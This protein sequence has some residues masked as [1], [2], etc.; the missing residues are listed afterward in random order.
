MFRKEKDMGQIIAICNQKGGVGKTTA[1][2][3][4]GRYLAQHNYKT[5]LLDADPQGNLTSWLTSS[6]KNNGWIDTIVQ[7][8]HIGESLIIINQGWPTLA[9]LPGNNN[10]VHAL[11]WLKVTEAP[12]CTLRNLIHPLAKMADYVLIDMP[13]SRSSSF[14]QLLYACDQVLVPTELERHSIEGINLMAQTAN[15][16]KHEHSRGPKLLGIIPNKVRN[17]N[18]HKHYLLSIAAAHP[19][20]IWP[21]VPQSITVT[22]ATAR[23]LSVFD[24]APGEKVTRAWATVCARFVENTGG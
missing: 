19:K 11:A 7:G 10:T 13:P 6:L 3:T 21:P 20:A 16:I 5:I 22:E 24:Y 17:C 15:K 23:G 8:H 1:T 12:F 9:L 18:E 2:A 14:E 4:I